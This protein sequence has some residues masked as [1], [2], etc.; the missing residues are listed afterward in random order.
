MLWV[1]A[2]KLPSLSVYAGVYWVPQ[3][4]FR[5][6]LINLY[7][8]EDFW[9]EKHSLDH[10]RAESAH[11]RGQHDHQADARDTGNRGQVAVAKHW[12]QATSSTTT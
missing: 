5:L 7:T 2:D 3:M 10:K 12:L 9:Q 1:A 6:L 8:E 4:F 11:Q